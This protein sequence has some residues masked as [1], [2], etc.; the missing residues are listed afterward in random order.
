M[1]GLLTNEP[2]ACVTG[3]PIAHSRSPLIHNYW[4]KSLDLKG[5][6]GRV[7]TPPDQFPAFIRT[8]REKGYVGCNVTLPNK[9]RAFHLAEKTT[10]RAQ[11][12]QAA[13]TLWF[14]GETL[15]ADNTDIEGFLANL[16]QQRPHWDQ[17]LEKAV[18]LGAGGAAAAVLLGLIERQAERIILVNRTKEKAEQ[19][20]ARFI[21]SRS[22]SLIEIYSFDDLHH[23]LAGATFL[24]NTTS[25][26]MKGQPPLS[27][28]LSP[29]RSDAIVTD[30]VYVPLI[31]PLLRHAKDAGLAAID[32]LGMLLH[33]AVPGFE[34]WFGKRPE[35]TPELRALVE[36]DIIAGAS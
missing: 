9:E 29:M 19:L 22:P 26:G 31:T 25:L 2:Q 28:D 14:E 18:V 30:I 15:C 32:G 11:L 24:V 4:L 16:D 3:H 35:V 8:M 1:S 13:N 20:A 7:D 5:H 27:L 23:V 21:E 34:H 10:A 17:S 12:M 6:Y 36:G 33:Q